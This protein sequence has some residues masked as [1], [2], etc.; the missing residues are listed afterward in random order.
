MG[1][2]N[3]TLAVVL[4]ISLLHFEPSRASRVLY[5]HHHEEGLIMKGLEFQSLPRGPVPPS[6]PS[7][8]TYIPGSGGSNCQLGEKHYVVDSIRHVSP[9]PR[10]VVQVGVATNQNGR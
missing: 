6:G 2:L 8:C 9:F 3:T 4:L 10:L 1:I 7:G 5:E